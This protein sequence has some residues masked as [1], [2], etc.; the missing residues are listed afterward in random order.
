MRTFLAI[1]F[2]NRVTQ[3]IAKNQRI[4]REKGVDGKF[5][6]PENIHLTLKFLGDVDQTQLDKLFYLSEITKEYKPMKLQLSHLG[7]FPPKG[8][9]KVLW[10]GLS[11]SGASSLAALHQKIDIFVAKELGVNREKR[12]FHPHVTL[13]RKPWIPK[14]YEGKLSEIEVERPDVMI[15]SLSLMK[16]ELT[17][18][19]PI[20]TELESYKLGMD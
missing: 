20:Y 3:A 4:C 14:E 6:K 12:K 2:E 16:S 5:V 11:G 18:S 8:K 17:P 13:A 15:Q 19:G 1:F 7:V 9:P 10:Q